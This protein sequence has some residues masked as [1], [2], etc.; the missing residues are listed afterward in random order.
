MESDVQNSRDSEATPSKDT[1]VDRDSTDIEEAISASNTSKTDDGHDEDPVAQINHQ[2]PHKMSKHYHGWRRIVR[3]F[4]PSWFV[5]NMGTGI[6]SILL[7]RLPYHAEWLEYISYIVFVLNVVLF[8]IFTLI[9][10]LRYLLYP[11]IW[12]AMIGHPS[13]SLFLGCFPMGLGTIINMICFVCVPAW[14]GGW[15]QLAWTLWWIDVVLAGTL[16][17][18]MPFIM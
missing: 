18:Y 5:V 15:W 7:F 17:C 14:G 6:T 2:Q 1:Y 11:R 3:N 13:Q 9:S 12:T 4:T 10:L 8:V 16:C